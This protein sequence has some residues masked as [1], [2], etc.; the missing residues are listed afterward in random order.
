M[1]LPGP[2]NVSMV[3]GTNQRGG[4]PSSS[5]NLSKSR[6]ACSNSAL[7]AMV[8]A[9]SDQHSSSSFGNGAKLGFKMISSTIQSTLQ[10]YLV[11]KSITPRWAEIDQKR[12]SYVVEV[13]N[14]Q[15]LMG[16]DLKTGPSE[17]IDILCIKSSYFQKQFC[18]ESI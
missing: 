3:Q 4:C 12:G 14:M 17:R 2:C 9:F 16:L 13:C 18:V 5:E 1:V 10:R 15:H 11:E 6:D 8:Q 7:A